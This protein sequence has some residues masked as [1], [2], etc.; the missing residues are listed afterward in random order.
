MSETPPP[1]HLP[2][3]L[4]PPLYVMG[5][6]LKAGRKKAIANSHYPFVLICWNKKAK[7]ESRQILKFVGTIR[8]LHLRGKSFPLSDV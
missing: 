8:G 1:P 6:A 3:D 5:K 2:E 4:D 7:L